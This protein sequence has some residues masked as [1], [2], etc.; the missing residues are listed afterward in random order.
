[1]AG[2]DEA[3]LHAIATQREIELTTWGRKTGKPSKVILWI[4]GGDGRVFVRSGGGL[5]R[6]W[7]RNFLARGHAVLHVGGH[8]VSV[9]GKHVEDPSL[10]RQVSSMMARKYQS[11]VQ[12]SNED[13]PLTPGESATFELF[14]EESE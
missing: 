9:T 12:H 13:E 2:F 6:D 8:D 3:V 4:T 14:P 10:A 7:P 1:M 5:K 11:N